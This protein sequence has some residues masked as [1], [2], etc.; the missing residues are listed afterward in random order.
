MPIPKMGNVQVFKRMVLSR[1]GR[2]ER[3]EHTVV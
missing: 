3:G 2:W 1:D